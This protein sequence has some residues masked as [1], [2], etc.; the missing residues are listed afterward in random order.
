MGRGPPE[1]DA[2]ARMSHADLS[3]CVFV[4]VKD[5]TFYPRHI[6]V[7]L[8]AAIYIHAWQPPCH[9]RTLWHCLQAHKALHL[10]VLWMMLSNAS[11][12][13]PASASIHPCMQAYP[14]GRLQFIAMNPA[15]RSA[16][17]VR[18]QVHD[19]AAPALVSSEATSTLANQPLLLLL[20]EPCDIAT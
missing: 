15:S 3:I 17:S 19:A 11:A 2:P 13:V 4:D 7:R 9:V 16:L 1:L 5:W 14:G 8:A 20:H 6:Q 10:F 12:R 18:L